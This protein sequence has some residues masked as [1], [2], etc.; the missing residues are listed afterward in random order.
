MAIRNKIFLFLFFV[1]LGAA[2]AQGVAVDSSDIREALDKKKNNMEMNVSCREVD[3][4]LFEKGCFPV[5]VVKQSQPDMLAFELFRDYSKVDKNRYEERLKGMF[6]AI[7]V[8][9]LD[10]EN[11]MASFVFAGD[12]EEK[13]I[14]E[15][16]KIFSYNGFVIRN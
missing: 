7:T 15:L 10:F 13:T 6:P 4:Y 8:A 16:V 12:I 3:G 9:T 2:R 14:Q 5:A 1:T 11:N